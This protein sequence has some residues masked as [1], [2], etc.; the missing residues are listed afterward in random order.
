MKTTTFRPPT[1][2]E[3][4]ADAALRSSILAWMRRN[5]EDCETST[6]LAERAAHEAAGGLDAW[7]DNEQ[8]WIWELAIKVKPGE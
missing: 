5:A 2:A 6:E 1:K 4:A 3:R 8:H 7:L